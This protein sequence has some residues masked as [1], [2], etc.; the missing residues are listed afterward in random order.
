MTGH[1]VSLGAAGGIGELSLLLL[2]ALLSL[3]LG[4]FAEVAQDERV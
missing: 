2:F 1:I 3:L 4:T